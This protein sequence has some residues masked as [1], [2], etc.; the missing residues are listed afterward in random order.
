MI[1]IVNGSEIRDRNFGVE[2]RVIASDMADADDANAKSFH[3]A[4]F[5]KNQA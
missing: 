4:T 2:S 1:D 3:L 5:F